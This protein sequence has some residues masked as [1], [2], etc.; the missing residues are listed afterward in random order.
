MQHVF[1]LSNVISGEEKELY[2]LKS[3]YLINP[4]EAVGIKS[5]PVKKLNIRVILFVVLILIC[6]ISYAQEHDSLRLYKKIKKIA[7]KHKLTTWAYNAVFVDPQPIEYPSQPASKKAKIVNPYLKYTGSIIRRINI[8]VYDPFGYSVEDTVQ[9]KINSF[10]KMGNRA[11]VTTRHWVIINKLLFKKNDAVNALSLSETER[12]LRQSVYVNDARI[13][14]TAIKNSDSV[15]VNVIVQDKW[16]ITVPAEITDVSANARFRN[17]NLLGT[18]QQF[19]Q[20]VGFRKPDLLGYNGFYNVA[21]ID[22]TYISSRFSYQTDKDGTS[23]GLSF[24][25]PF[26]SPL[27]K[28]AGGAS[29]NHVQHFYTYKDTIDGI[30]KRMNLSNAGY[31]VW[32]GKSIKLSD[33][34]SFFSQSNNLIVT[35]RYYNTTYFNKSS[36]AYNVLQS[37]FNTSAF[38]GNIGYA[39]QQ[40]YKDKFIYR[41][42]ANEDVPEGL[43]VQFLYGAIKKEFAPIRYYSG[44]EIARAKDFKFG[45]LSATFSSGIFFNKFISNDITTN[46]RFNYF[47]DL[48]RIRKW[49]LREFLNYSLV[50]GENKPVTEK[51]TLTS[52]DL[53][54]FESGGL[55]GN[56]KMV[57]NFETVAYAPYNLIGFRFAPVVL[58]GLGMISDSRNKLF[59]SH[60]YQAY[61]MGLMVRNEN[62]LSSTFQVSFGVYPILPNSGSY[63]VKYNP[64][65]S[66]TLRVRIFSIAKP[67]F[68]SY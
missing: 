37:N 9:R 26:Y 15:D 28:W 17:D 53:Y 5:C 7:Y 60:L 1:N 39:V 47:S 25:R 27:T 54:G 6:N 8:T 12:L 36:I 10:E 67:E 40:Y 4:E 65:T 61:S 38:I 23:L 64:V 52:A 16:P 45:Y 55:V 24:D 68:I 30:E 46:F 49:Y 62:L 22:H 34:E 48:F 42:G 29:V 14:I 44:I 58:V 2:S 13:F 66:F 41:F 33:D 21:N 57:L 56:T 35:G 51:T 63:A 31:D 19:E 32:V 11:H 59:E 3:N 18:G 43:I 20:Y 50:Y